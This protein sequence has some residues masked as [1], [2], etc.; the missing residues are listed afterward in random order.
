MQGLYECVLFQ[1]MD[2]NTVDELL[3]SIPHAIKRYR[4]GK[5][6]FH[7]G[8]IPLELGIV[9]QGT[10]L[11]K[12][13]NF[14]GS[15]SILT[16][17]ETSEIFAETFAC[18]QEPLQVDVQA[19]E[20]CEI[21][22]VKPEQLLSL[23]NVIASRVLSLM[24]QKNRLLSSKIRCLSQ[25]TTKAKVLSYLSACSFQ[26]QS[27][28]FTI[29]FSRQELADYLAVDRSALSQVISELAK[30]GFLTYHKNQFQLLKNADE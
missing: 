25:R 24:A 18:L 1:E 17:I 6:I 23:S 10:L 14:W 27:A 4:K 7:R 28:C 5:T 29:P 21:L 11:L 12:E 30:D 8:T 26:K 22:F 13:E 15:R 20:D 2:K 16:R 19:Y 9:M 3:Q